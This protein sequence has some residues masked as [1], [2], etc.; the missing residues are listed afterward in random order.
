MEPIVSSD[1][2][3]EQATSIANAGRRK[4]VAVAAAQDADVIGAVASAR[5]DGY[6]NGTLVGDEAEIRSL[7]E[8]ND[9]SLEGLTVIDETDVFKAAHKAVSLAAEGKADLVMK[10]FLPTSGLLKVVLDKQ[11]GLR[12]HNTLS[13]CALLDIPGYHKMLNF[14]DG[15]M[16]V[17]PDASQKM[18]V[19]DNSLL[20]ASALGLEPPRVAV[21][22]VHESDNFVEDARKQ[23]G[24]AVID[25]PLT[26]HEATRMDNG[27][28][29]DIFLVDSIEEGNVVAKSLINFADAVFSGVIV[30]ARIP[31]SLVS[32]TDSVK[33]K[34]SSL[35]IACVLADYYAQNNVWGEA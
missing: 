32:R 16:L 26:L 15:G 12:G 28:G 2:L 27:A 9:V 1:Q 29:A 22:Q 18:Q 8:Q 24:L 20:V 13:H 3:I 19:L 14:T 23:Y 30:G 10:G 33:N 4:T 31:V 21:T 17:K 11:Y 7:A 5:A 35:A 25:G 6:I 34:K